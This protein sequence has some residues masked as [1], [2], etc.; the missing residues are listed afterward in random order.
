[1][2][3]AALLALAGML[4]FNGALLALAIPPLAYL[5]IAQWDA[6]RAPS[7]AASHTLDQA[8]VAR[9]APV[10]VTLTVTGD[11][12]RP[13]DLRID[14]AIPAGLRLVDGEPTLR[15]RLLPG[16]TATLAYRVAGRRGIYRFGAATITS[17]EPLG[18]LSAT[19]S[20]DAPARLLIVPPATPLRRLVIRA[21]KT[22][23]AAGTVPARLGG[24]GIAFFGVRPYQPGD[25]TRWI[26]ARL[27][28]RHPENIVVNEFEQE[29]AVDIGVILDAR[30]GPVGAT[31]GR[32][33]FDAAVDAAAAIAATLIDRGNRVGLLIYG[34]AL[35]WTFP[36]YGRV[37]RQRVLT[38]LARAEQGDSVA[39]ERL[40]Y[41]P[42]RQFPAGS[43]IVLISSGQGDDIATLRR[44]RASAYEVLLI[45]PDPVT[46]ELDELAHD[47]AVLLAG[48]VT[49]AERA[50]FLRQA[51]A[52]GVRVVDWNIARPL[53]EVLG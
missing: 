36:G 14:A 21:R 9:D 49:A 53:A 12:Q 16:E 28:A 26:N 19:A 3:A 33:L 27:M 32:E 17:Y 6:P 34:K 24:S 31:V 29:R 22:R 18:L 44:L 47:P 40:D 7:F 37:Q 42:T 1:M 50:L 15:T 23:A 5:A 30:L 35:D 8:L 4:T 2:A 20:V 43:Q 52:L 41:L 13:L 51:R 10:S 48:R 45:S 38:A 39:F 25:P 46:C 11:H